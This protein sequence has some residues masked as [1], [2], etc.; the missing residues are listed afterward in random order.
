MCD[1]VMNQNDP[2]HCHCFSIDESDIDE[3]REQLEEIGF[4]DTIWQDDDDFEFGLVLRIDEYTQMHVKV[5]SE[6]R[7]ESEIEYPPDY[8]IAHLNQKHSHSAHRELSEVFKDIRMPHKSR[9]FPPRSCLRPKIVSAINP[10]HAETVAGGLLVLGAVS[11]L[12]YLMSR[13]RNG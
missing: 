4:R 2:Y 1:Q 7:I 5:D 6:G 3:F 10:S 8:P 12:L 13:E 11:T 9:H